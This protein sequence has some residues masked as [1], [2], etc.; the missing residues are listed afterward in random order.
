MV[1]F[2]E[3]VSDIYERE[4][5]DSDFGFII[6]NN[7]D[8]KTVFFP[9]TFSGIIPEKIKELFQLMGVKNPENLVSVTLH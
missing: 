6:D 4:I 3:K 1:N 5:T 8:L 7:G 2:E 9:E